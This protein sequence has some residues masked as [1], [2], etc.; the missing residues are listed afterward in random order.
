MPPQI[1][2]LTS[3]SDFVLFKSVIAISIIN[4]H[5]LKVKIYSPS[6]INGADISSEGLAQDPSTE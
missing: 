1:Q 3:I 4:N 2:L 5:L 6:T